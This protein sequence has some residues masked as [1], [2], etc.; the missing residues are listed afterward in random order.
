MDRLPEG[1]TLRPLEMHRDARGSVTELF[2]ASWPT[3]FAPAQWNAATSAAGVVRGVHVHPVHCDYVALVAGRVA[4]GLCDLRP[5]SPT[6][7]RAVCIELVG[8]ELATLVIPPGV[9]HGFHFL[10]PSIMV[11]GA[12]HDFDPADELGCHWLDPALGIPWPAR[13][14]LLS[15]RDAELGPLSALAGRLP[16]WRASAEAALASAG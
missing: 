5:G 10:A 16:A 14:A 8:E 2:R 11:L 7:G 15:P 9:A 4:A 3:G 12:S 1:V 6:E 13:T